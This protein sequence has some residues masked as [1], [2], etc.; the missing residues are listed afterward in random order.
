VRTGTADQLSALYHIFR[1]KVGFMRE[2]GEPMEFG[3]F[4]Y[5]KVFPK[6]FGEEDG[7]GLEWTQGYLVT[8]W[9]P[10]R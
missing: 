7:A 8:P 4:D 3:I 6:A 10:L 9:T 2:L 5:Y 1:E